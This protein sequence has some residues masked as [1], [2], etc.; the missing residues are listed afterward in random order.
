[1]T[2][3]FELNGK[4]YKVKEIDFNALCYLERAGVDMSNMEGSNFSFIRAY[5]A[6][7]MNKTL[8]EAG[9]EIYA[10]VQENG[11]DSLSEVF[12]N[13]L[14]GMNEEGFSGTGKKTRKATV[15]A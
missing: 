13:A 1:M 6:Y 15:K 9:N 8:E 12:S 7:C 14:E 2:Q 5:F 4:E 3:K 11:W 10:H